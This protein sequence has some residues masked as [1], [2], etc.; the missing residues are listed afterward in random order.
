MKKC[1]NTI[2][3]HE[4]I[5]DLWDAGIKDDKLALLF[6]EN[7]SAKIAIKTASGTTEQQN[8]QG[9]MLERENKNLNV[10]Q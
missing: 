3:L 6:L 10:P 1:H 5:N 4:C 2:W 8:V 7:T 9:L